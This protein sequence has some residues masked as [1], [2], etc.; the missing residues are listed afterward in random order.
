MQTAST[1]F[2]GITKIFHIKGFYN[3]F[4]SGDYNNCRPICLMK[5]LRVLTDITYNIFIFA[6]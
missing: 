2:I 3:I 4:W 5:K 1:N 6:G